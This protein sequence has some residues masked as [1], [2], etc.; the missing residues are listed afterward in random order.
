M[1]DAAQ[2]TDT[3]L[4][5]AVERLNSPL[6]VRAGR[7]VLKTDRSDHELFEDLSLGER[8]RVVV[9]I[10]IEAVGMNGIIVVPQELWEGLDKPNRDALNEQVNGTGVVIL[11]A[12]VGYESELVAKDYQP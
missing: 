3:V 12:Q 4:S 7:L 10:A 1:R 6:R 9:D 2:A 11:T 8:T 5:A